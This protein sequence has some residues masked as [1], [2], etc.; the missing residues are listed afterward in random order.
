V[1]IHAPAQHGF[2]CRARCAC[3]YYPL[4]VKQPTCHKAGMTLRSPS[5]TPSLP[6][7]SLT[8][9]P[10]AAEPL[11]Q[12]RICRHCQLP[13]KYVLSTAAWTADAASRL[14]T[15]HATLWHSY[16]NTSFDK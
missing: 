12:N 15:V 2:T 6:L 5:E 3:L 10:Q 4:P 14:T 1:H 9:Q 7:N 13:G 16:A 11:T 8:V